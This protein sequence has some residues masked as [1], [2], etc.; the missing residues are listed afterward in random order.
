MIPV[1]ASVGSALGFLT[2]PV[3]FQAVRSWYQLLATLDAAGATRVLDEMAEQASDIVRTAAGHVKLVVT[4]TAYMRYCGQGHEIPVTLAPG[5][6][7]A[8]DITGLAKRFETAYRALYGRTI[9][10]MGVE[11]MSWSVTVS[12]PVK[13][14][15]KARALPAK[16]ATAVA[17]RKMLEPRDA[18]WRNAPVYER[19][20]MPPGTRIAGP[21]LIVEDQTTVV[22]TGAFHASIDSLGQIVLERK[23]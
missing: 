5:T 17:T 20:A 15:P 3:A 2:A 23:R 22:V 8:K 6:L 14:A 11:I 16:K 7:S 13:R 21:A 12:T 10:G 1:S 18:K 4:R 19:T 9:P